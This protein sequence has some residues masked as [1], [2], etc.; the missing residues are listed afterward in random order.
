M[1]ATVVE[2]I[3]RVGDDSCCRFG[4]GHDHIEMLLSSVAVGEAV[5]TTTLQSLLHNLLWTRTHCNLLLC[6]PLSVLL[7]D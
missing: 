7:Y 1:V 6:S 3:P 4:H 2:A 5:V